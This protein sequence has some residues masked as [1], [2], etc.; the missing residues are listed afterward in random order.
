MVLT[1][2]KKGFQI[3]WQQS[4][5]TYIYVQ[6]RSSKDNFIGMSYFTL[7]VHVS[8]SKFLKSVDLNYSLFISTK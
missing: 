6:T 8:F 3:P 1:Q 2:T 4:S 5:T 7:I